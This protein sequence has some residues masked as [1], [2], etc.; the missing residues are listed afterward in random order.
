MKVKM[1]GNFQLGRLLKSV[2]DSSGKR[3]AKV[4]YRTMKKAQSLI[5]TRRNPNKAS[6]PGQPPFSHGR[7]KKSILYGVDSDT[8]VFIGPAY[9]KGDPL[10]NAGRIN[11]FGGTKRIGKRH[12]Y[13]VGKV[14]PIDIS[15]WESQTTGRRTKDRSNYVTPPP[16]EG[17]ISKV[18]KGVAFVKLKTAKQV[19]RAKDIDMARW[20]DSDK[21]ATYPAR[22]YMSKTLKI[23]EPKLTGL[24]VR[25]VSS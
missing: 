20:P 24:W 17:R 3:L 8:S 12:T 7:F 9:F 23:M 2:Q 5:K 16:K 18:V 6:T 10:T 19:R 15:G 11:E 14:G 21:T 1:R 25:A 22:P 4:G 13:A